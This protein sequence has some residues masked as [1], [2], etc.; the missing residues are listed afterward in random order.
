MLP[1]HEPPS[2]LKIEDAEAG[3][4]IPLA[5][6]GR[7]NPILHF[8]EI[9]LYEDDLGDQGYCCDSLRYRVMNDC[10]YVLH[11]YYLRVDEVIVRIFDTRLFHSYDSDFVIREFQ[12]KE[13]TY[14]ELRG[15]GFKISS[16]WSLSK[17][18]ADEVFPQVALKMKKVD[19]I[20]FN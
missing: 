5:R 7:D 11:R 9:Y 14:D 10:F 17:Q 19:K 2:P 18:Q 6:L 8:G 3:M 13:S 15:K 1:S 20:V 12:Y 16:E 4:E